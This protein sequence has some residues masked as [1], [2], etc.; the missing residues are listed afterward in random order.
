MTM[1]RRLGALLIAMPVATGVILT[2]TP[3]SANALWGRVTA[4]A[5]GAVITSGTRVTAKAEYGGLDMELRVTVP[6]AGDQ[7]LTRGGGS[8]TMSAP[9][10]IGVNGKYTVRLK[11]RLWPYREYDS[12]TFTVRIPPAAPSGVSASAS[13]N[14]LTVTWNLGLE[15]DLTGYKVDAGSH[16]SKSG[17]TGAFCSGTVCSHKFTLASGST[18]PATVSVRAVRSNGTGGTITSGP[19][20]RTVQLAGPG[21]GPGGGGAGGTGGGGVSVGNLPAPNYGAGNGGTPL[22]PF[23]EQSPVT[24][25]N[26]QPD[27][28]NPNFAYPEPVV[29]GQNAGGQDPAALARL[30]WSKSIA[31]ALILL[32]IAAHLGTWTRRMRVAQAGVSSLGM[33]AR[34][35]RSGSGRTRVEKTQEH[36]ARAEATAKAATATKPRPAK[37]AGSRSATPT[38]QP[39][40]K[41]RTTTQAGKTGG[42][43]TAT[44]TP[45]PTTPPA[46]A[47]TGT[48]S[49]KTADSTAGTDSPAPRGTGYRFVP[50]PRSS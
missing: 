39:G 26:V 45:R 47:P 3:G 49:V 5:D 1:I 20:S 16:G 4:P 10:S 19:S 42:T 35:A 48:V 31:I 30:Q 27:G 14:T 46:N 50:P 43:A 32:V 41:T 13:G 28:A 25:P 15:D 22:T 8:G 38:R 33:A 18:G 34:I 12:S 9:V 23:N 36:I 21:G 17:S 11:G 40:T 37:D 44:R 24:L 29:A 6:G 7:F 2:G